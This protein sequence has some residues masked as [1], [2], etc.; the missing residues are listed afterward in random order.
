MFGREQKKKRRKYVRPGA[1]PKDEGKNGKKKQLLLFASS[2]CSSSSSSSSSSSQSYLIYIFLLPTPL[3]LVHLE[4]NDDVRLP[5]RPVR[6]QMKWPVA[7][8]LLSLSLSLS[9]AGPTLKFPTRFFSLI[10][11]GRSIRFT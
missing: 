7:T 5:C 11:N 4:M 2:S 10:F 9:L 1:D 8:T 3:V 6:I